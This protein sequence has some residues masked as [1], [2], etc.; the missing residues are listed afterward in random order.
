MDWI[1]L[2]LIRLDFISVFSTPS[3]SLNTAK[4]FLLLWIDYLYSKI[5]NTRTIYMD[6]CPQT[7]KNCIF[8]INVL[9][10]VKTFFIPQ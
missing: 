10:D 7:S 9:N 4:T 8:F 3:L 1:Y 6:D 5:I 2:D